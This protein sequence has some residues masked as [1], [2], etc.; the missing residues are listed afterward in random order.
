MTAIPSPSGSA[1]QAQGG[2][3]GG[4][5]PILLAFP[6]RAP[7]Q[8]LS[9]LVRIFLA[10]PH[11]I[12]LAV[13]S[14]VAEI[15]AVIGWFGA[16]F[17][18]RLPRFAE[19][20]LSGWLH[21][22]ARVNSYCLLLTG[23]YPPFALG[24]SDYPVRLAVP[25]PGPLNRLAVFFRIILAIPATVLVMLLGYG[26]QTIMLFVT[27]LVVLV[28]GIMPAGLYQAYAAVLRYS[29]RYIG[30]MALLTGEYPNALFGDR[31]TQGEVVTGAAN[32]FPVQPGAFPVQPGAFP[33]QPGAFPAQPG[34]FIAQP[35][36][37]IAQPGDLPAQPGAFIAEPGA[38][39]AQPGAFPAQPGAV[40][41]GP[42]AFP[43]QPVSEPG[44]FPPE[45]ASFAAEPAGFHGTAGQPAHAMPFAPATVWQPWQ[46]V[47]SRGARRLI[48]L[49][50]GLGLVLLVVYSIFISLALGKAA[51]AVV[52][53]NNAINQ[54][55]AA[56]STLSKTLSSFQA[57]S[58]DCHSDIRCV[59][60]LD[61]QASQAFDA[62]G[63][64]V[65]GTAMPDGATTSAAGQLASASSQAGQLLL[66]LGHVTSVA[67]YEAIL[68]S[69]NVR[70]ILDRVDV[71]Y[72]NL[73]VKLNA[74]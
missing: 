32:T 57:R 53:R 59:T 70:Q 41:V 31:P 22:Q 67:Q 44:G 3:F 27:W 40:I 35:G 52:T 29:I 37:F 66:R 56:Y 1:P 13:L 58:A 48:G 11:L 18:G 12:A 49:F 43:A 20:Y 14:F 45:P 33:A 4:R 39:P 24:D 61:R 62:F 16:L 36:G 5:S 10:L 71:D 73:G 9:V 23:A 34:G 42:G 17:T 26:A 63:T 6:D 54:V 15:V 38:F 30:Y 65:Q 64:S 50:L 72:Q 51:N 25:P 60:A 74:P 28:T 68:A 21:W 55:Q 8:R 47:L 46:L 69:A 19:D 2:A 7:Q